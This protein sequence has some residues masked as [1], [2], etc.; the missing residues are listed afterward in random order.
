MLLSTASLVRD[1]MKWHI[2]TLYEVAQGFSI[3]D[4]GT[5]ARRQIMT[6]AA[7]QQITEA[8]GLRCG[9]QHEVPG[10]LVP[11]VE[12]L[13][14]GDL[15]AQL[16]NQSGW[17]SPWRRACRAGNTER[18]AH[19]ETIVLRI[20]ELT[21]GDDVEPRAQQDAGDSMDQARGVGAVNSQDVKLYMVQRDASAC[22]NVEALSTVC[23]S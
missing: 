23:V 14:G 17:N 4:D 10:P 13:C 20:N 9:K 21:I 19:E 5:D 7:Q 1:E 15:G 18:C 11:Q 3:A 22:L 12:M 8:V 2:E 6:V 16:L